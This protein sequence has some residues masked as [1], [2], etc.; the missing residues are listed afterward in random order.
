MHVRGALLLSIAVAAGLPHAAFAQADEDF[1]D[2]A[3]PGQTAVPTDNGGE[4]TVP[5]IDPARQAALD[6]IAE[7]IDAVDSK[8]ERQGNNWEFSI[9]EAQIL[10]VTDA[11][12]NRMRI[13]T[14]IAMADSV[15]PEGLLRLLQANFDTALDA[16]YAVAQGLVWGTF[17]HPLDSLDTRDFASGLLQ[18]KSLADTYGT[19]FSSGALS[20][21]GGDSNAIIADELE[22]LLEELDRNSAT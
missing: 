7:V 21:G 5:D 10:V 9:D 1:S 11:V 19:S 14:P 3:S 22:E 16:R 20:Y 2:V 8:A 18:T 17:I 13:L 6:A 12:N 15:P 4:D